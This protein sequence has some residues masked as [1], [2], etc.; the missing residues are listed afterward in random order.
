MSSCSIYPSYQFT[1]ND[2]DNLYLKIE[3]DLL[4]MGKQILEYD[5]Y[6]ELADKLHRKYVKSEDKCK[7]LK[8]FLSNL[9]GRYPEYYLY[10]ITTDVYKSY[11]KSHLDQ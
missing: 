10:L 6:E 11:K 2:C 4:E 7:T 5:Y 9:Y 3:Q 8:E 1:D